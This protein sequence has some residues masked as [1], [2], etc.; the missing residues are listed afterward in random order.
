[1]IAAEK[2]QAKIRAA[3]AALDRTGVRRN[4]LDNVG[5]TAN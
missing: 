5:F 2:L 1:M 3:I 4:N